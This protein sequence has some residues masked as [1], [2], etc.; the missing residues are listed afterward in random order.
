MRHRD[1][2][3]IISIHNI[4]RGCRRAEVEVGV[5][6]AVDAWMLLRPYSFA[7]HFNDKCGGLR[8]L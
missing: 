3:S 5:I 1:V 2:D 6:G 4:S 7:S 8:S